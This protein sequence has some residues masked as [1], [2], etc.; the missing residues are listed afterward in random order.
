MYRNRV[1][2]AGWRLV[3]IVHKKGSQDVA[4]LPNS[5]LSGLFETVHLLRSPR[6]AERLLAALGRARA[7][8]TKPGSIEDLRRD[9]G[10]K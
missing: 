9:L 7:G 5:E 10:P 6:N 8:K 1:H 2:L 3:V 4:S